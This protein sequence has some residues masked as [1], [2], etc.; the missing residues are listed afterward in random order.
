MDSE[1]KRYGIKIPETNYH[2]II[3]WLCIGIQA[4]VFL[5]LLAIWGRLPD[6]VPMHYNAAGEIDGYGGKWTV[7]ITPVSMLLMHQFLN[8]VER[9]PDWWNTSVSITRGNCEK[10]YGTLKNMIVSLKFIVL[11]I[12]GYMS[13]QTGTGENIGSWFL[14]AA[15]ILTFGSVIIFCILLTKASKKS[16]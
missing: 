11:L 1:C 7:W 16:K 14:P 15:L 5:Y 4:G 6:K 3:K 8:L 2:R 13:I 12:F 10:V 9:H